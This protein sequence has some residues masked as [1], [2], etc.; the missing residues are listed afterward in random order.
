MLSALTRGDREH[1][2]ATRALAAVKE[3]SMQVAPVR[4]VEYYQ[5]LKLNHRRIP[6]L[7]SMKLYLSNELATIKEPF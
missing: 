7:K 5:S 4:L 3:T 2:I 1:C 6:R